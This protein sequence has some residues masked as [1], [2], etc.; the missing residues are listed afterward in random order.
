MSNLPAELKELL[1]APPRRTVAVAESLTG[2]RVQ[3]LITGIAGASE[4]FLGGVTAYT[5][6]Q[7]NKLLGVKREHAKV[8]QGVSEHVA[9][10]MAVGVCR[11]FDADIAVATTGYA[12]PAPAQ[13]VSTPFA[14]LAVAVRG[15]GSPRVVLCRRVEWPGTVRTEAQAA[16]AEAALAA[17]I[18]VLRVEPQG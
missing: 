7:K 14:W 9:G 12:E 18:E 11:M 3:A 8:V 13:G 15:N 10:E 1:L 16:A 5:L 2:G 17:L 6:E 4:Y